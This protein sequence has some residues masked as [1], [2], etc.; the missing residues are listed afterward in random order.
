MYLGTQAMAQSRSIPSWY[1]VRTRWARH[2]LRTTIEATRPLASLGPPG[3]RQLMP[4]QLVETI[5]SNLGTLISFVKYTRLKSCASLWQKA[6]PASLTLRSHAR[7]STCYKRQLGTALLRPQNPRYPMPQTP[8]SPE[9][10]QISKKIR[11]NEKPTADQWA[12][13]P[14]E[15][16]RSQ[17]LRASHSPQ[18]N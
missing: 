3:T 6:Q 17:P 8:K 13:E 12:N 16:P 4:E 11:F 9:T 7:M 5:K 10:P 14:K 1:D 15:Q 2:K 18:T